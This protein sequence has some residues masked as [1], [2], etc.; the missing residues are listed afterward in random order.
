[1]IQYITYGFKSLFN[2]KKIHDPSSFISEGTL[3]MNLYCK[4]VAMKTTALMLT[5]NMW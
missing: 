5:G 3:H 2:I 1:M 4:R